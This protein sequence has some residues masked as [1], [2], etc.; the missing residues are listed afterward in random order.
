MKSVDHLSCSLTVFGLHC[1]N[2]DAL[3]SEGN[4]FPVLKSRKQFESSILIA[5]C[6]F[7]I[8]IVEVMFYCQYLAKENSLPAIQG[9]CSN[10]EVVQILS[11][12]CSSFV[13]V[14][15]V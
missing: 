2:H 5:G 12:D 9:C 10:F 3:F 7:F 8:C 14:C 1:L 15:T 6:L 4:L 11:L 13:L